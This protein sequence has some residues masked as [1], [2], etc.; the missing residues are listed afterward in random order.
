MNQLRR[1]TRTLACM[2]IV[3]LCAFST[4][5]LAQLRV[6]CEL[7]EQVESM[8]P[9]APIH[10]HSHSD[11][12]QQDHGDDEDGDS[13]CRSTIAVDLGVHKFDLTY[14]TPRLIGVLTYTLTSFDPSIF[15]NSR[16]SFIHARLN[17][18]PPFDQSHIA[19]TVLRL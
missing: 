4:V 9:A 5:A 3:L 2:W 11:Q 12:D 10:A 14:S 8:S 18:P 1:V 6:L 13:C 15:S 19:T 7:D 16:H 17:D